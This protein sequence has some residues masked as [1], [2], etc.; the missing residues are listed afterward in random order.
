MNYV[1]WFI[2]WMQGDETKLNK[3]FMLQYTCI[4]VCVL[5]CGC[6]DYNFTTLFN[7]NM[8]NWIR[9]SIYSFR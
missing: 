9:F 8:H 4:N 3:N 1:V 7:G 2:K 6:L 5:H